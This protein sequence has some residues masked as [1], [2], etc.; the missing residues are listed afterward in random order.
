MLYRNKNIELRLTF[1][2]FLGW[3][4]PPELLRMRLH[5]FNTFALLPLLYLCMSAFLSL[6][7]HRPWLFLRPLL[8]SPFL[9][10][11]VLLFYS[12]VII[13]HIILRRQAAQSKTIVSGKCFKCIEHLPFAIFALIGENEQKAHWYVLFPEWE[14]YLNQ[15]DAYYELE[16]Y[17]GNRYVETIRRLGRYPIELTPES[18]L[19]NKKEEQPPQISKEE[20]KEFRCFYWHT[21]WFSS[22]SSPIQLEQGASCVTI[23]GV[24]FLGMAIWSF[25]IALPFTQRQ[26]TSL[27]L[28]IISVF[29]VFLGFGLITLGMRMEAR[30]QQAA[31][32]STNITIVGTVTKWKGFGSGT[33]QT[34]VFKVIL[35]DGSE[36][37]FLAAR[38]YHLRVQQMGIPITVTFDRATN[39]VFDI[40]EIEEVA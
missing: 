1:L 17:P 23:G 8:T 30:W 31:V 13:I 14:K 7:S 34:T 28:I 9:W 32:S 40:Q 16:V 21:I 5:V 37:T 20:A 25:V 27:I 3:G 39:Y 24:C 29:C 38:R 10:A 18:T 12:P 36:R 33:N 6:F 35:S 11:C 2:R 15:P 26:N 22:W 19:F 4:N